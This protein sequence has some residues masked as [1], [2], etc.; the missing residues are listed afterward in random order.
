MH[1]SLRPL[2]DAHEHIEKRFEP[3]LFPSGEGETFRVVSPV[4]LSFDI[5]R[6]ETGR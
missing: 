2:Q 4:M 3:S 5:D 1:L 6:Q